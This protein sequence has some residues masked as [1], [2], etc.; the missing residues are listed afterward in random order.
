MKTTAKWILGSWLGGI[1]KSF[2]EETWSRWDT[3][4][5]L[6][7]T[8]QKEVK[9]CKDPI[10]HADFPHIC[11]DLLVHPP[12]SFWNMLTRDVLA[13]VSWCGLKQ[14]H[15]I[16]VM[17]ALAMALF[18]YLLLLTVPKMANKVRELRTIKEY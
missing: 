6:Y 1:A 5:A 15:N 2:V 8:R 10:Y 13:N 17:E 4:A 11:L 7:N 16:T 18:L 14:C 3:V 12:I 9:H